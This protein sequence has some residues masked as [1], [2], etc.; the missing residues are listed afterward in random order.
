[1]TSQGVDQFNVTVS[2]LAG[3]TIF[4]QEGLSHQSEIDLSNQDAGAYFINVEVNG[5]MRTERILLQ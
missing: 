2:D 3:R 5:R 1:M 4:R